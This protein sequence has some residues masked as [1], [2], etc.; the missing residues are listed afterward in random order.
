MSAPCPTRA[1]W[2]VLATLREGPTPYLHGGGANLKTTTSVQKRGWVLYVA[3]TRQYT[4]SDEGRAALEAGDRR[5]QAS[6][7]AYARRPL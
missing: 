3:R 1:Q 7:V 2:R 4:L 6:E 5:H